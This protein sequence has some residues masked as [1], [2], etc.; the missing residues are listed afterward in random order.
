[1]PI[2]KLKSLLAA[3]IVASV[4]AFSFGGAAHAATI[5]TTAATET[6]YES[7]SITVMASCS[8][9]LWG[10]GGANDTPGQLS[11][12][13]GDIWSI[14]AVTGS[15]A[16]SE[17][18]EATFLSA[19]TGTSFAKADLSKTGGNS[20]SM[21]FSFDSLY[22]VIKVGAGHVVLKN[23]TSSAIDVMWSAGSAG[24]LSHYTLAGDLTPVPAPAA[25]VLLL[26]ALG[27]LGLMRRRRKA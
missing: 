27:G 2:V 10:L 13:N 12:T 20:G 18:N 22:A 3:A 23:N 9:Y 26:G 15:N 21:T 7:G 11:G 17:A 8:G 4:S 16:N 25:G 6:C 5:T 14:S 19:V 1:M 24:G